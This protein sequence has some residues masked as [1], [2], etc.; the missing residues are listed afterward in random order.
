M[1]QIYAAFFGEIVKVES[2]HFREVGWGNKEAIEMAEVLPRFPAL[3]SLDVGQNQIGPEGARAIGESLRVNGSLTSLN[4]AANKLGPEGATALA[5]GVAVNGSL[6]KL[7]VRY[8]S[9]DDA[10][11]DALKA[12][13]RGKEGFELLWSS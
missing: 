11:K 10:A 3:T 7:D 5:A 8:N 6:T 13:A 1:A 2:L 4:L 9:L 12:A